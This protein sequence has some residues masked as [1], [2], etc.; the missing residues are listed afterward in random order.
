MYE[1]VGKNLRLA[2]KRKEGGIQAIPELFLR[3][4]FKKD[5]E[6]SEEL[7]DVV[8]WYLVAEKLSKERI[9]KE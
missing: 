4:E 5:M 7:R 6:K 1:P 3:D 9:G 8:D 2:D